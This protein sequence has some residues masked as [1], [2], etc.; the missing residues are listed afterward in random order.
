MSD[1]AALP[2]STAEERQA[3]R[4][5]LPPAQLEVAVPLVN[6][7][8]AENRLVAPFGSARDVLSKLT[9]AQ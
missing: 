6:D 9:R 4:A 7:F 5:A 3:L 8:V 1:T 2:C